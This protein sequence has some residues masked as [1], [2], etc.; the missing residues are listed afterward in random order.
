M[1]TGLYDDSRECHEEALD[2]WHKN[3][4]DSLWQA[5][6]DRL[7]GDGPVELDPGEDYF[8]VGL[9]GSDWTDGSSRGARPAYIQLNYRLGDEGWRAAIEGGKLVAFRI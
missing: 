5:W 3:L 1:E 2:S 6:T 4:A 8:E 9:D 7:V